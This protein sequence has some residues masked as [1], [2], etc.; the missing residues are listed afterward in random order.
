MDLFDTIAKKPTAE[1]IAE[2]SSLRAEIQRHNGLYH[3]DD[4]PEISDAAFDAM[5]RRHNEIEDLYPELA[6]GDAPTQKVGADLSPAFGKIVH[7]L[8]MLSL[9]NAFSAEDVEKFL[10]SVRGLLGKT[11]A[12]RLVISA[13]PK[14]DGLSLSLRYE[15]R[16]EEH[17][18]ELQSLMRISY[19]VFCLQKK[20]KMLQ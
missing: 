19:A 15:N 20:I 9:E 17:T 2:L 6:S 16:S 1:E 5:V 18:S 10:Q 12:D 3:T 11:P 14:I 7:P 13:E 8:P 4:N